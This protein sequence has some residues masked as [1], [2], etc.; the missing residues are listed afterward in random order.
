MGKWQAGVWSL[1]FLH[2]IA[3]SLLF[4]CF[5]VSICM[6]VLCTIASRWLGFALYHIISWSGVEWSGDIDGPDG[7]EL[8]LITAALLACLLACLLAG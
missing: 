5:F 2:E 4:F 3:Q 8:F 1:G 6:Y 7:M